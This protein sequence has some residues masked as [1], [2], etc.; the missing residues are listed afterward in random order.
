VEAIR[1]A[2]RK[3][4]ARKME[5]AEGLLGR[6]MRDDEEEVQTHA[7]AGG[8]SNEHINTPPSNKLSN[9]PSS[10]VHINASLRKKPSIHHHPKDDCCPHL[11]RRTPPTTIRPPDGGTKTATL[12]GTGKSRS[13]SSCA[14]GTLRAMSPG[15]VRWG[16]SPSSPPTP[17]LLL[18]DN[19]WRRRSGGGRA[20]R[21]GRRRRRRR[22]LF[23]RGDRRDCSWDRRPRAMTWE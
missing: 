16:C 10:N 13:T 6:E 17:L 21:R 14:R 5:E 23:P 3:K 12:S 15:S 22:R 11:R 18:L 9:A 2:L 1:R 8:Q 7:G 19:G 20:G 4:K